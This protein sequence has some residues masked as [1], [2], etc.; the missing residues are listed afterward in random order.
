MDV[1]CH[2]GTML[3]DEIGSLKEYPLP[4]GHEATRC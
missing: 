1:V 4:E 2:L 3:L